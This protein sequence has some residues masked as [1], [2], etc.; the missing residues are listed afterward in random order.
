MEVELGLGTGAAGEVVL[1]QAEVMMGQ[2]TGTSVSAASEHPCGKLL[3]WAGRGVQRRAKWSWQASDATQAKFDQQHCCC[4]PA[5]TCYSRAEFHSCRYH[6]GC[7]SEQAF[8][9]SRKEQPGWG[10]EEQQGHSPVTRLRQ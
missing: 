6:L 5:G 2:L 1:V 7:A 8:L 10:E 3:P 4:L 9:V